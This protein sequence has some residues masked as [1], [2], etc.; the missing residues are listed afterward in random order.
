[1]EFADLALGQGYHGDTREA[2][3][4]VEPSDVL[5]VARQPIEGL[6]DHDI[7]AAGARVL[8]QLLVARPHAMPRNM[9]PGQNPPRGRN[10]AL[11]VR[12]GA[13]SRVEIGN[14]RPARQRHQKRKI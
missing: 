9:L 5:L 4:L 1:M 13:P 7:E 10:S 12:A 3:V 8:Y 11:A 6:G 2:E 14:A